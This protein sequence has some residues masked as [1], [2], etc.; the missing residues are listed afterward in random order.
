MEKQYWYVFNNVDVANIIE[1]T[2]GQ[3]Y[4]IFN[5]KEGNGKIY[6]FKKT[7]EVLIAYNTIK[8]IIEI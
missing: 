2:T 4:M 3:A 7:K 5:T 6:S 8:E 1:K